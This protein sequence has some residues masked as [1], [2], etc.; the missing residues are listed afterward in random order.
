M[1]SRDDD[2]RNGAADGH[3]TE[4]A[5]DRLWKQ[6][7]LGDLPELGTHL[8][9]GCRECLSTLEPW[10]FP[11]EP[12]EPTDSWERLR[13]WAVRQAERRRREREDAP[14]VLQRLAG[15]PSGR[16]ALLLKSSRRFRTPAVVDALIEAGNGELSSDIRRAVA[17]MELAVVAAD[18][19]HPPEMEEKTGRDFQARARVALARALRRSGELGRAEQQLGT[20]RRL[21]EKGTGDRLELAN[22][23]EEEAF[24]RRFQSRTDDA[25]SILRRAMG[26]YVAFGDQH[27]A[28]RAVIRRAHVLQ[29]GGRYEEALRSLAE[30]MRGIDP[31]REPRW[32]L[33]IAHNLAVTLANMGRT[34][35]ARI[36]LRRYESL[37]ALLGRPADFSKARWLLGSMLLE[38]GDAYQAAVILS[39]VRDELADLGLTLEAASVSLELSLAFAKLG[40][41]RRLRETLVTAIPILESRRVHRDLLAALS[42]LKKAAEAEVVTAEVLNEAGRLLRSWRRG[43]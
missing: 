9:E 30:A 1:S 6:E 22:A 16:Q 18:A 11:P 19:L 20:A 13:D 21:L 37:Y 42:V 10:F 32:V 27:L 15:L 31:E 35:F 29:E 41:T 3:L 23:L 28:A 38:E 25:L 24:L 39:G 26:I 43:S 8:L 7:E 40:D 36:I 14:R 5:L 33:T 34:S 2:R 17:F 4:E 12:A